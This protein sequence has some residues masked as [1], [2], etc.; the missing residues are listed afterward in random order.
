MP[1]DPLFPYGEAAYNAMP[2]VPRD[3]PPSFVL[4]RPRL[5]AERQRHAGQLFLAVAST[6]RRI[7]DAAQAVTVRQR[8]PAACPRCAVALE[9]CVCPKP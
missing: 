6:H 1:V 3:Q 7:S 2:G 5:L 4:D 8:V 9:R